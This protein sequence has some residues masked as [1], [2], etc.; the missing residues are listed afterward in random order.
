MI[1]TDKIQISPSRKSSN[2]K[3]SNKIV[4]TCTD[5]ATPPTYSIVRASARGA[6]GRGSI[7][8]RVTPKT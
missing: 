5:M 7:P 6:G 1:S 8:D 2:Y 4:N 3:A